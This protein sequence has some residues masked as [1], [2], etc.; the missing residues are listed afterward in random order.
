VRRCLA[1][2][3]IDQHQAGDIFRRCGR[4]SDCWL[5]WRRSPVAVASPDRESR[6]LAARLGP[7]PLVAP[8][9]RGPIPV[10]V[11]SLASMAF[12]GSGGAVLLS[13]P[14][15]LPAPRTRSGSTTTHPGESPGTR[16]AGRCPAT[17]PPLGRFPSDR[18]PEARR[19]GRDGIARP[20][21]Q[22]RRIWV[23]ASLPFRPAAARL[24]PA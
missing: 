13:L 7:Q 12:A 21:H 9:Q 5:L 14:S 3:W 17:R 4:S 15:G 24:R 18:S 1:A 23:R 19:G 22:L 10:A 2:A 8:V 6:T 16:V 11:L 20:T